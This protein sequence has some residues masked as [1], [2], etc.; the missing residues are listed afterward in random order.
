MVFTQELPPKGGYDAIQWKRNLPSSR[1]RPSIYLGI[2]GAVSMFGFY[3]LSVAMKARREEKREK[4][5]ARIHLAPM[6][7]AETDRDTVRR[8]Y[9]TQAREKEIMKDHPEW[10]DGKPVYH[11]GRLHLP[12]YV[13][14]ENTVNID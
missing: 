6:L 9:A 5:W 11:D 12:T 3:K 4:M 14:L 1:F 7:Q 8:Y 2:M 13:L 10:A